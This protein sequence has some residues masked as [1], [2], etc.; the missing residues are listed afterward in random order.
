MGIMQPILRP[1]LQPILRTPFDPG[2]GDSLT[3]AL[4][5]ILLGQSLNVSRGTKVE[6]S[7]W[8][9]AYMPV[10]AVAVSE[11]DFFAT[12]NEHTMNW[13]SIAS[14][15]PLAEGTGQSPCVGIAAALADNGNFGRAYFCSVAVGARARLGARPFSAAS[16]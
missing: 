10:D 5:V 4:I 9:Q 12:N 11:F 8:D 3:P 1:I 14:A 7:S 16:G 13:T 2:L 6:E 15:V